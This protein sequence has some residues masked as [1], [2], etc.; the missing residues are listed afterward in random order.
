MRLIGRTAPRA[1]KTSSGKL[2]AVK[3]N[4]INK[5]Y[6]FSDMLIEVTLTKPASGFKNPMN[7]TTGTANDIPFVWARPSEATEY[8]LQIA[9]DKDFNISV[10]TVT[11][12]SKES[13]VLALVGPYQTGD[14]RINFIAGTTYY[15]R[16]RTIR[17]LYDRYSEARSFSIES[18]AALVP[19]L[20]T[21]ANGSNGVSLKPSFSWGPIS[22]ATEYQF[23]LSANVTMIPPII[24]TKVKDAGF[25][26]TRELDYGSTYFWKVRAT[27]PAE[28]GWSTLAN[29]TVAKKPVEKVPPPVIQQSPPPIINMPPLP[30]PDVEIVPPLPPEV[31]VPEAPN[32]LGIVIVILSVLLLVVIALIIKPVTTRLF[33]AAGSFGDGLGKLGEGLNSHFKDFHPL[34]TFQRGKAH[35]TGKSEVEDVQSLSFAVESFL[36]ML[37]SEG[38]EESQRGLSMD[39]EQTM[40][41]KLALKIQALAKKHLLYQK[42]PEDAVLFL[43]LWAH[44]GSRDE[45]NRYLTDSFQSGPEN[46]IT[47]LRCYLTAPRGTEPGLDRKTHFSRTQYDSIARV[48]DPASIYEALT[49]LYG[50][51]LDMP[52]GDESGYLTDK[53]IASQ[54]ARVHRLVWDEM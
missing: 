5:L 53:A 43:Y 32:Y 35:I 14:A 23:V 47:L 46:V 8:E 45:T 42:F 10:A 6:S 9:F 39:E 34:G 17:P 50:S 25:A 52:E 12:E 51:E 13:S 41:K 18:M 37:T 21:P 33:Q 22:G 1:L 48:I 24:D 30:S 7:V 15:W 54:F 4:G 3:T 40:G 38:K 19:N 36:W 2:W 26:M 28:T 11:V 27:E 29:F 16:V 20:L 49:R 31:P 44:Y